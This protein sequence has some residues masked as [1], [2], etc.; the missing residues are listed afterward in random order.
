MANTFEV[1]SNL[2]AWCVSQR[3]AVAWTLMQ[4]IDNGRRGF[5][6]F[7]VDHE[8]R[9]QLWHENARNLGDLM[10][11]A[12]AWLAKGPER[13]PEVNATQLKALAAELRSEGGVPDTREQRTAIDVLNELGELVE[14]SDTPRDVAILALGCVLGIAL[15]AGWSIQEII[16]L[17]AWPSRLR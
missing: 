14:A 15:R 6:L 3:G 1:L 16:A 7:M 12:A 10:D 11:A 8:S 17:R 9:E 5:Q 2:S 4:T 13:H